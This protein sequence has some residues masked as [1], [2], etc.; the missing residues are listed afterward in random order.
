MINVWGDAVATACVAHLS[1]KEIE[2]YEKKVNNKNLVSISPEFYQFTEIFDQ[3][4]PF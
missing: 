1:E 3:K 2:E 4:Y